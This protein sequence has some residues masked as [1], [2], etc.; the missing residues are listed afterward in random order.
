[1]YAPL[2]SNKLSDFYQKYNVMREIKL[3]YV[4]FLNYFNSVLQY[5]ILNFLKDILTSGETKTNKA[6]LLNRVIRLISISN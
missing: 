4:Y 5:T 2:D 3:T 6:I 1:M